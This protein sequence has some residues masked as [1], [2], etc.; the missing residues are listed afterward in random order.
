MKT[1]RNDSIFVL[2]RRRRDRGQSRSYIVRVGDVAVFRSSCT[3]CLSGTG[4]V[5][6]TRRHAMY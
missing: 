5:Q 4:C 6:S 3:D 1:G 2:R